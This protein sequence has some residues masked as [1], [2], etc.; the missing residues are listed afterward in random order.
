L[1]REESRLIV[2]VTRRKRLPGGGRGADL[3]IAI[4]IAYPDPE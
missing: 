1:D 4:K 2:E 3:Y